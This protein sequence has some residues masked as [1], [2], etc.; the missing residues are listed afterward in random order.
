MKATYASLWNLRAVRERSFKKFDHQSA[1]MGLSIQTAYKF[2]KGIKI[3]AN[4]VLVTRVLGT[5]SV[6]GQQL[7]T[8]VK[9]GLVTNPLPDT[10]SELAIISFDANGKNFGINLLQFAKPTTGEPPLTSMILPKDEMLKVSEIARE[11]EIKYCQAIP[12]Y[13]AG[14]DCKYVIN[15]QSKALA[16]DMEFKQFDNGEILIKQVRTFSGR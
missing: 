6:Y 5:E 9:N 15:S 1:S 12:K 16:L 10:K 11:V 2:R 8:Q 7:S 3:K 13:F 14:H 4:S